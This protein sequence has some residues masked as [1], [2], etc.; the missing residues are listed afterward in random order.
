MIVNLMRT[1]QRWMMTVIA[2]L[3]IVSFLWF[4]SDRSHF[5]RMSNDRVGSVYGKA[6]TNLEF[7]RTI[8]QLNTAD[9]LGLENLSRPE[10][11]NRRDLISSAINFIVL[12]HR[13]S[14]FGIEPAE[15][16]VEEAS[17]KIPAFQAAGGGGFDP[18][19]YA[20]FV[21][22]KLGPRG[23]SDRQVDEL[24]RADLQIGRL[25]R[26]VDSTAL[27]SP[28][29]VRLA[30]DQAFSKTDAA[31][32]RFKKAEFAAA[33][34]PTGDEI[35]KYFEDQKGAL[36]F[37]E[38]RKV[39]YV[40]FGLSDDQKT[41]AGKERVDAMKPHAASAERFIDQVLDAKGKADFNALAA[42]AKTPLKESAE[43]EE[44]QTGGY[45]EATIPNFAETVFRLTKEQPD[46]DVIDTPS[47]YY[48][49][50]LDAV[51]PAKPMT[52]EEATPKIIAALKDDR[53]KAALAAKA[54]EVRT[55]VE[56]ALKGGKPFADAVKE[57][58]QT[59]LD[60]PPFSPAEP[61]RGFQDLAEITD[62]AMELNVGD[63]SKLVN[64]PDGGVLV[65]VRTRFGV[66]EKKF[67]SQKEMVS[68]SLRQR[69]RRFGFGE[70]L[71]AS[72]EAA[73]AHFEGG[74]SSMGG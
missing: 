58:G 68:N 17:K 18:L 8:R 7:E 69:K 73:D 38:K 36:K 37:P 52:L 51:T 23:F 24:V 50:H 43:I 29:E 57:A 41:L 27:V 61:A 71:R 60:V 39:K 48:I 1:N 34:T 63:L 20:K 53:A 31:V 30:Y 26:V 13:A 47:A 45:P 62:A 72:R 21:D 35:T 54:E 22:E 11:Y 19:R 46:S 12:K 28:A 9:D 2:I 64:T 40:V 32:I 16:E 3:V 15:S 5:D 49:L 33:V 10:V 66:D 42:E 67:E 14:E 25:L 44:G 65:Y 55:K 59:P 70:W 6:L 4:F 56:A 74:Q